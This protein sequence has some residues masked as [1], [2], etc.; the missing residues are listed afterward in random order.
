MKKYNYTSLATIVGAI[1]LLYVLFSRTDLGNVIIHGVINLFAGGRSSVKVLLFLIYILALGLVS[2][3]HIAKPLRNFKVKSSWLFTTFIIAYGYNLLLLIAYYKKLGT[4]FSDFIITFNNGEISSTAVLH[5]HV[6]KGF[7]SLLLEPFGWQIQENIDTGWAFVGLIPSFWLWLGGILALLCLILTILK[8][9][10]LFW[11]EKKYPW[12]FLAFYGITTFALLKNLIDGGIFNREAPIA[13]SALIFILLTSKSVSKRIPKNEKIPISLVPIIIYAGLMGIIY[14]FFPQMVKDYAFNLYMSATLVIILFTIA[15]WWKKE[16]NTR[17]GILLLVLSI[18]F[19][20]IPL[21]QNFNTYLN[22]LK[23]VPSD[24]AF[25]GLYN[26]PAYNSHLK[27][28]KIESI[29]GLSIYHLAPQGQVP[30]KDIIKSND[31]LNNLGPI[32]VPWVNCYP[33]Y[34]DE[35]ISFTMLTTRDMPAISNV[36]ETATIKEAKLIGQTGS[37][38][39]YEMKIALRRCS[40]RIV[41]IIEELLKQQGQQTFFVLN[42]SKDDTFVQ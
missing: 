36:N 9:T 19:S 24:G 11:E 8:F 6:M 39:R 18:T 38:Y 21:A 35:T 37:L 34:P 3:P 26:L 33:T 7:T 25:V 20:Y 1:L 4:N 22:S 28:D 40:P 5:S 2:I 32:N 14:F 30:L 13:L 17:L 27:W 23:T 10:E 41:N 15:Y 16:S 31:L 29:N 42:L 12:V